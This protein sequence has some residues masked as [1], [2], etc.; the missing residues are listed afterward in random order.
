MIEFIFPLDTSCFDIIVY[1]RNGNKIKM[2]TIK[3]GGDVIWY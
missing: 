1:V 2:K 3:T